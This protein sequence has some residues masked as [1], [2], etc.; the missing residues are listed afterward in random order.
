MGKKTTRKEITKSGMDIPDYIIESI[1]RSLLPVIQEYYETEEC[2][3]SF[4]E[5]QQR[6]PKTEELLAS[7]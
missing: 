6:H 7:D 2:L 5:W 3:K 1:A 4:E